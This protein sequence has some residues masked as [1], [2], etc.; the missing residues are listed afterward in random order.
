MPDKKL[1]IKNQKS[2]INTAAKPTTAPRSGLGLSVPVY[3]LAGATAGSLI[4]PKEIFGAKVN[5]NLLAQALRVYT[6]NQQGHHSN[7]K[8]RGEVAGS[9]R[10]IFKQKG[11]GRARHGSIT[12]PIFV[13]GGIA[14]GPK[15][16]KTVLE[17]PQKMKKAALVSAL[18]QRVAGK[19]ALGMQGLEK[20][21]GKTKQMAQLLQKLGKKSLL[22]VA[23]SSS[24]EALRALRNIKSVKLLPAEDINAFDVVR[25]Q[26]LVLTKEAVEKLQQ[27]LGGKSK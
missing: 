19:E 2:K 18:S 15:S 12:A 27:R 17:L 5:N 16:R 23:D 14:L 26:S 11:T 10:K 21:S 1:K 22:I 6:V 9:T 7:T 13:G 25:Y 4:L 8:T 24:K 20:A 3:S